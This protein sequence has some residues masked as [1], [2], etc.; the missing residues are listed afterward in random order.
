[1]RR[2]LDR[3]METVNHRHVQ[4]RLGQHTIAQYRQ[5][6]RLRKLPAQFELD[7]QSLPICEGRVV[8]IRWV[9]GRGTVKLLGQ[10]FRGDCAVK[11]AT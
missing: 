3:L 8:F 2:E 4:P 1:M 5:R 10:R 7:M 9:S 6:K 11:V